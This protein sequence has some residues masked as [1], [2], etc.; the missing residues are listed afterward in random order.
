MA[1][2]IT[3][4]LSFFSLLLSSLPFFRSSPTVT[5]D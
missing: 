4:S 3:L 5:F 2:L 1:A